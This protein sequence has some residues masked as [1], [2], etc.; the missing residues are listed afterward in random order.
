MRKL[1]KLSVFIWQHYKW[2]YDADGSFSFAYA[3]MI[4]SIECPDPATDTT[5]ST[6]SGN[7]PT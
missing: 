6:T 5:A 3:S 7:P 1:I 4:C 2:K